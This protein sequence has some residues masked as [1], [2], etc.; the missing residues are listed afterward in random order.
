MK[1]AGIRQAPHCPGTEMPTSSG[2]YAKYDAVIVLSKMLKRDTSSQIPLHFP[3]LIRVIM[4][5]QILLA[6]YPK[7]Q[8]A[9]DL[10]TLL[11]LSDTRTLPDKLLGRIRAIPRQS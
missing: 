1:K 2:G 6:S 7:P 4:N 11:E 9:H 10:R 5:L 8:H 3:Y